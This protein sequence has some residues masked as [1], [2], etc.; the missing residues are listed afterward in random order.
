MNT[1]LDRSM[2]IPVEERLPDGKRGISYGQFITDVVLVK[3]KDRPD[4]PVTAHAVVGDDCDA[5]GVRIPTN[6]A[7]KYKWICWH[8]A[9]RD[10]SNPFD[11]ASG[12]KGP[13]KDS[14]GYP[15]FLPSYFGEGITHWMPLP[16]DAQPSIT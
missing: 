10:L 14:V 4:Y 8:S 16:D 1:T 15:R 5:L 3:H 13:L 9:G 12:Y 6:G 2:W 7:S 11:M